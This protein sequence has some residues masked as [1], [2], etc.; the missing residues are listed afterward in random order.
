[1]I[2]RLITRG[3]AFTVEPQSDELEDAPAE[4]EEE[5]DQQFNQTEPALH[6]LSIVLFAAGCDGSRGSLIKQFTAL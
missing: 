2:V 1:M 3:C 6:R 4:P 5:H